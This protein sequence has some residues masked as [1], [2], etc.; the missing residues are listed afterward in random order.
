M[1]KIMVL[2]GYTLNPGD[3][4]WDGL[5]QLG[6]VTV[7]DRT[8]RQ[9][10]AARIGDA[11]VVL[12]NKTPISREVLE[13]CPNLRYIG[14][15]ATG[16]NVVDVDAAK[17]RGITVTNIPTYGTAAVSQYTF[18]LLLELC[19]Q[20]GMHSKS[21]H[22]GK[23]QEN[24]DFC[25]WLTPQMELDGKTIGIIGFGRIGKAVARIALAF[26][27]KVLVYDQYFQKGEMEVS[28]VE[29]DDLLKN[30]D[31]ITLHCPLTKENQGLISAENIAK[32]K[33]GVL[34]LNDA[35]GGLVEEQALAEALRSG[36]VAGAAVDVVSEEPISGRNP[37]LSAPNC[38][39][40]P[41]IAWASLEARRRLMGVAVENVSAFLSGRPVNLV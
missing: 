17:E 1:G 27:M 31:V 2:D 10:T 25:Y 24:G 28:D 8:S 33:D 23:W 41:H 6:E 4:S 30:S 14:V 15:L 39:I 34:L 16:Y 9:D 19:H 21:V 13:A 22:G 5:K 35:R 3:L 32:M 12:T 7:Y 20:A 36:K 29:L 38:I 40:T 37:L 26:G 18:A 11:L